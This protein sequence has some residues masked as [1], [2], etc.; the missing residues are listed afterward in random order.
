[1]KTH[2]AEPND[3]SPSDRRN[4][5]WTD[6]TYESVASKM[7]FRLFDST[8]NCRKRVVAF[9]TSVN[10]AI[11]IIL[12][13]GRIGS[14]CSVPVPLNS[15]RRNECLCRA[16]CNTQQPTQSRRS[17]C[18]PTENRTFSTDDSFDFCFVSFAV[19]LNEFLWTKLRRPS[20][21]KLTEHWPQPIGLTLLYP[22]TS[23]NHLQCLLLSF[24]FVFK[25][26]LLVPSLPIKVA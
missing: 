4:S 13:L 7:M 3:S 6:A 15:F 2:P 1:M 21:S 25:N 18:Q 19:C 8:G 24:W 9:S 23:Q 16:L 22:R 20:T 26:R 17:T 10:K 14:G 12:I 11:I 5:S